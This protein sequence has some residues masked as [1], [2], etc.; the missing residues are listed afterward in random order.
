MCNVAN[1]RTL[2][3]NLKPFNLV[4][5]LA[6]SMT[7]NLILISMAF[8]VFEVTLY[9]RCPIENYVFISWFL[10]RFPILRYTERKFRG[11]NTVTVHTSIADA[12][13]KTY[14][15]DTQCMSYIKYGILLYDFCTT[16]FVFCKANRST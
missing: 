14:C 10:L 9:I 13:P 2:Y 5:T 8:S 11:Y 4:H 1:N 12:T 6:T 16:R 15:V 7:M 3:T